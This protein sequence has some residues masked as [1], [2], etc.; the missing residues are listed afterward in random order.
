MDN[1]VKLQGLPNYI[2]TDKDKIFVS[3]FWK[4]L[5]YIVNLKLSTAYHP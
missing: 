1:V 5:L 4:K 3:Q 2:I